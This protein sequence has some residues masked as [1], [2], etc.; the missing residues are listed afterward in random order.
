ME[1]VITVG[2]DAGIDLNLKISCKMTASKIEIASSQVHTIYLPVSKNVQS[3]K[4]CDKS[5]RY[6]SNSNV[7]TVIKFFPIFEAVV[8]LSL[9]LVINWKLYRKDNR[10]IYHLE[11]LE[12]EEYSD[13]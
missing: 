2:R 11:Y 3:S 6:Y 7:P 1:N 9:G 10:I 13:E 4:Y 5:I 12:I 8:K